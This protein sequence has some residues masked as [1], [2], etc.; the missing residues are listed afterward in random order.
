MKKVNILIDEMLF[1]DNILDAVYEYCAVPDTVGIASAKDSSKSYF[2]Y[3]TDERG[4]LEWFI[5]KNSLPEAI[6]YAREMYIGL[7]SYYNGIA[8][9]SANIN[10]KR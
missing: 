4:N 8:N 9:D 10:K 1:N 6:T 7:K 5:K 3:E 2:V